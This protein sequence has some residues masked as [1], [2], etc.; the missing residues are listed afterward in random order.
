MKRRGNR[1]AFTLVELLVVIGIIALLVS[2]LLPALGRARE[3]AVGIKCAS[4]L[5]SIGQGLFAYANENGGAVP[6]S[7]LYRTFQMDP[8][9]GTETPSVPAAGYVHWSSYLLGTVQ[10]DAFKCP[11]M[12]KG[13]LPPTFPM[14]GNW[15]SGQQGESG[16]DG[17]VTDPRMDKVTAKDGT[18]TSVTYTPDS[19]A[20]RMGYTLNEAICG[21]NKFVVG[22]QSA[23]DVRTYNYGTALAIVKNPAGTIL[24][25]EFIDEPRIVTG[26]GYSS[27][28]VVIKSHRPTSGWRAGGADAAKGGDNYNLDMARVALTDTIRRTNKTDLYVRTDATQ[29]IEPIKDFG[30]GLYTTGATGSY[31]TRLDW[32]GHNHGSAEHYVDKKSNFLYCDGH[33]EMKNIIDTIPADA[34]HTT[35]WEW[36]DRMYTLSP[37]TPDLP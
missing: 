12:T 25:T 26:T 27:A 5:R 30:A 18:N 6:P 8:A 21:R 36:G 37:N 10:P 28:T 1:S 23:Q 32:V 4:N 19:Q 3:T 7:Y 29:S 2:I 15:D 31:M 33:V 24:A 22:F 34:T 35:P 11:A 17:T 16:N 13:G 9:A 20:P 14:P